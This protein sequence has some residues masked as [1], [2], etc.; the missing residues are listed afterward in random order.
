MESK[1]SRAG[2]TSS[3]R[4]RACKLYRAKTKGKAERFNSYLKQSFIAPLV[5]TLKQARLEFTVGAAN[6]YI[7][8]WLQI[9]T[10]P[11]IIDNNASLPFASYQYP[12]G[13]YDQLLGYNTNVF[14]VPVQH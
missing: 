12:V 11:S 4:P 13:V 14:L 1:T 6:N 8:P 5:A 2:E 9:N 3:N 7:R 10:N